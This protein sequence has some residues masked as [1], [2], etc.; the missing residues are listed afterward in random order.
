MFDKLFFSYLS[1]CFEFRI[2]KFEIRICLRLMEN[3]FHIRGGYSYV[4]RL[5][6]ERR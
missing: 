4:F 5:D 3:K 1:F 2:S 6:A